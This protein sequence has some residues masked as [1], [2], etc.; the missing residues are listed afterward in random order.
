[1]G[2]SRDLD[3][4]RRVA[5]VLG[6]GGALVIGG[7]HASADTDAPS[8][9]AVDA[10][11]ST[12]TTTS[13]SSSTVATTSAPPST[14]TTT[15]TEVSS[16]P[17]TTSQTVEGSQTSTV[18]TTTTT[19]RLGMG[20][21]TTT[22]VTTTTAPGLGPTSTTPAKDSP[23]SQPGKGGEAETKTKA[24]LP[25]IKTDPPRQT[26]Q[27]PT[28]T[29]PPAFQKVIQS[30][31]GALLKII[32][33]LGY[34]PGTPS[35]SPLAPLLQQVYWGLQ[36]INKRVDNSRPTVNPTV[37]GYDPT[38]GAASGKING[39]D[40]DGD[41]LQYSASGM[42]HGTVAIDQKA[43][44]FVY[45]PDKEFAHSLSLNRST[46]PGSDTITFTATDDIPAN[47]FHTHLSGSA[48]DSTSSIDVSIA[49]I[50]S[51]PSATS[52]VSPLSDT[53]QKIVI[54]VSDP[55]GDQVV[56][57]PSGNP[58][59]GTVTGS[60]NT[61][62][63]QTDSSYLHVLSSRIGGGQPVGETLGFT[64]DDG[65]G[66]TRYVTARV[67]LLSTNAAPVLSIGNPTVV[68][69][70]THWTVFTSDQ[71]KDPV[72]LSVS[73]AA[74]GTVKLDGPVLTYDPDPAYVA[75]LK[76][77]GQDSF[78]VTAD[79]GHGG[80]ATAVLKPTI[81]LPPV[82]NHAPVSQ[83]YYTDVSQIQ[84][85][86]T[87]TVGTKPSSVAVT[88]DGR[89]VITTS[90]QDGAI[91]VV[92]TQT[93]G[94]T[95]TPKVGYSP[96][97][98]VAPGAN[99]GFFVVADGASP[100]I[101][102]VN[103]TT[104]AS[105]AY[106][107]PRTGGRTPVISAI[108]VDTTGD[109][110]YVADSA[111]KTLSALTVM[112]G[113]WGG[114]T[115]LDASPTALAVSGSGHNADVL[116]AV[117]KPGSG[118]HLVDV[119]AATGKVTRAIDHPGRLAGIAANDS[120]F[121]VSYSTPETSSKGSLATIAAHDDSTTLAIRQTDNAGP[122]VVTGNGETLYVVNPKSI[123]AYSIGSGPAVFAAESDPITASIGTAA[124]TY[125]GESLYSADTAGG[126]LTSYCAQSCIS[127]QIRATDA[128]N[129]KLTYTVT[130]PPK[131]GNVYL[132]SKTGIYSYV[133]TRFGE[134]DSFVVTTSDGRGGSVDTKVDIA[135]DQQ[136][137]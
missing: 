52:V 59:G 123:S 82:Q 72:T 33:A 126:T 78:T 66:G 67:T 121:Y 37:T 125:Y 5:L 112:S 64:V 63:Y 11:T 54:N 39:Y 71:E 83:G 36:Q 137:L 91:T 108:A 93:P 106:S 35:N 29:P 10:T 27:P 16:S 24:N 19:P 46:T 127:G 80:K 4:I 107:V 47:G 134:P 132:D 53:T 25:T 115:Q 2:T 17:T 1:M 88:A 75:G 100:T 97:Y 13:S 113:F 7:G 92:D 74:H 56:V 20:L 81:P 55:D 22:A 60:G 111:G 68:L 73:G 103:T 30:F 89:Y 65:H 102:V 3:R 118:F 105:K 57:T 38:T 42:K 45:T 101:Y 76:S 8:S 69:E 28:P 131:R 114:T 9:N 61:F 117:D 40:A 85:L 79:D 135:I 98:V 116:V 87:Q 44:T 49:P 34:K 48:A 136:Q 84:Q 128:D 21:P 120:T 110:V 119:S 129:D 41:V 133:F 90:P 31:T 95:R 12:P 122:L 124:T 23:A 96:K 15:T 14:T 51:R 109:T 6:A 26:Q 99:P 86:G 32:D 43:G 62:V 130:T 70:Q 94:S 77:P 50:N 58:T 18:A 104:W